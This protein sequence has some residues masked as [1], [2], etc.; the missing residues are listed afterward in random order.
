MNS[1]ILDVLPIG[2][3]TD[4]LMAPSLL[5]KFSHCSFFVSSSLGVVEQADSD[6]IKAKQKT[7]S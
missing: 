4:P 7:L 3:S 2:D 6:S 1:T 5:A